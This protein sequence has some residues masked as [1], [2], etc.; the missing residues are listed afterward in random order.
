MFC[1][2]YIQKKKKVY[3]S[4]YKTNSN[5]LF[6]TLKIL[7]LLHKNN[8]YNFII[9]IILNFLLVDVQYKPKNNLKWAFFNPY[10]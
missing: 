2:K 4:N 8:E 1:A 9:K 6:I 3:N 5:C 7:I 10:I